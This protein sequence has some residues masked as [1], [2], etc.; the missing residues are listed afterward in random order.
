[1]FIYGRK[2]DSNTSINEI[3]FNVHPFSLNVTS[4]YYSLLSSCVMKLGRYVIVD[5]GGNYVMFRELNVLIKIQ[6]ITPH[7]N[8]LSCLCSCATGSSKFVYF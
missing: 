7:N 2:N 3:S 8:N 5:N 1:M 4:S 6:D